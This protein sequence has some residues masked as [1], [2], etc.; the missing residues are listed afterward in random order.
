MYPSAMKECLHPISA[1]Y[2]LNDKLQMK[3]IS[4]HVIANGNDG[5]LPMR[6]DNGFGLSLYY[7]RFSQQDHEI[8]AGIETGTLRN[9]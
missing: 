4:L 3:R 2:E 6:A 1:T 7:R 9:S 8:K 5:A